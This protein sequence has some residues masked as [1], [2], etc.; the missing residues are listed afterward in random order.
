MDATIRMT[1]RALDAILMGSQ[2]GDLV[3]D[4]SVALDGDPAAVAA[5]TSNLD[6][7]EFWFPIVTP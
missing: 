5:L 1:R 7:F 2:I 3:A 6:D 4:G